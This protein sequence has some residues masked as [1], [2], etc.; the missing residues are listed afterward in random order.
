M[1]FF[2]LCFFLL[3]WILCSLLL[4]N[5]AVH[6]L[7]NY[8]PVGY[9]ST[10]SLV[11]SIVFLWILF[12]WLFLRS[13]FHMLF[14]QQTAFWFFCHYVCIY[15]LW[16]SFLACPSFPQLF[17]QHTCLV[18]SI[19]VTVL[20]HAVTWISDLVLEIVQLL[21]GMTHIHFVLVFE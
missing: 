15:I 21:F 19:R 16:L 12:L 14:H 9:V 5:I 13:W 1:W 6:D 7:W 20:S 18:C 10:W 17:L 2:A 8:V 11:T 4:S 3:H